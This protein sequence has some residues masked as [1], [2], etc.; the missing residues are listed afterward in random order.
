MRAAV[1]AHVLFRFIIEFEARK[2]LPI[3]YGGGILS[4]ERFCNTTRVYSSHRG[5]NNN[6]RIEKYSILLKVILYYLACIPRVVVCETAIN[7]S[8]MM[9]DTLF[10]LN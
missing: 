1:R 3:Y 9:I 4:H 2:K 10:R 5:Q 8:Y 6:V 7:G